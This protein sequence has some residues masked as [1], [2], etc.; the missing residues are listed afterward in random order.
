MG[1]GV[2]VGPAP[3]VAEAAQQGPAT[4]L[5]SET[6]AEAGAWLAALKRSLTSAA[7]PGLAVLA[8]TQFFAHTVARCPRALA[9][10]A[11]E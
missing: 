8:H 7:I 4:R 1:V 10:F 9:H 2:T 6:A 5:P 3:P 11:G